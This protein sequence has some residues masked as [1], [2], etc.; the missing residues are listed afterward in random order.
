VIVVIESVSP[1]FCVACRPAPFFPF[2]DWALRPWQPV[3]RDA[4]AVPG[5]LGR[6][7][8]PP[9]RTTL[10]DRMLVA[11]S[12]IWRKSRTGAKEHFNLFLRTD[13]GEKAIARLA[14]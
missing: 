10:Y 11:R 1:L 14:S 2:G 4:L 3:C 5:R 12:L 7:H 6:G 8:V 9:N 13:L